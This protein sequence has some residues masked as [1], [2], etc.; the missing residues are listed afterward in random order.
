[1]KHNP[2]NRKDNVE[3]IQK[4]IDYTIENIHRADDMIAQTSDPA[5]KEQL[6]QKNKRRDRALEGMRREIRDEA[7]F[8][9]KEK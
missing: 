4:N 2:D 3:N 9:D 8:R 1:M 6:Q 7:Q 5:A